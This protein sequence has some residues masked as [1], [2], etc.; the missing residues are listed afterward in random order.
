MGLFGSGNDHEVYK[1][2]SIT[3]GT[4][5]EGPV[6]RADI[7]PFDAEAWDQ[8]RM[9][10]GQEFYQVPCRTWNSGIYALDTKEYAIETARIYRAEVI[11]QVDLWGR[12][13]IFE[14]GYRAE[15]CMIKK[16]WILYR[17]SNLEV[18]DCASGKLPMASLMGKTIPDLARTYD[19]DVEVL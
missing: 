13:V 3:M 17:G 1:L 15:L 10:R 16:L 12:V 5:W 9:E 14:K 4:V 2:S 6:L 8:Y 11:G 7:K 19:C 18:Q